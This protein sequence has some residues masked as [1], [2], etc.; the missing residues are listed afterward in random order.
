MTL[1]ELFQSEP[2]MQGVL[3]SIMTQR[4]RMRY[5]RDNVR[6]ALR[7]A[8]HDVSTITMGQVEALH[9]FLNPEDAPRIPKQNMT[10][11]TRKG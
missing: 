2:N 7:Q 5:K 3:T 8:G 6:E 1:L 11:P 10:R 9:W 4:V